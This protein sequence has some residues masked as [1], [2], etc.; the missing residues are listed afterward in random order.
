MEVV[1]AV[2]AW[3]L[4]KFSPQ[5]LLSNLGLLSL[6]TNQTAFYA[7]L[8][9]KLSP[10][11]TILT[12]SEPLFTNATD[13]WR[14]FHSPEIGL[15]VN[16]ASEQ[17]VQEAVRYANKHNMP[18]IARS[19]GHG[20][21][22]ALGAAKN[23]LQIDMRGMNHVIISNDGKTAKIGGG[24]R[25]KEIVQELWDAGKQTVT[26]ICECVGISA[27]I[28]GGG[29]GWL[30]GQYGLATDQVVEARMILS[31]GTAVTVSD[32]SN[33]DLFWAIR[34]A[35]HNFGLVT[36]WKYRIHDI[37]HQNWSYEMFIFTGD[38]LEAIY[39]LTNEMMKSQPPEVIHWA[40]MLKIPEIDPVHPIIFYAIICDGPASKTLEYG[41]PIRDLGPVVNDAG[42]TTMPALA[43]LTYMSLDT[44][45]CAYGFTGL[46]YPIGMNTYNVASVRKVYDEFD[47]MMSS[48]PELSGSF[49]LLEGYS[50]HA[51]KAVPEE[52]TAFAHRSDELL[53]TPYIMY[54]P[55]AKIDPIAKAFGAT[56]RQ[57]LLDGTEDP[58]KLRAYVNY[59]YGD[60]TMQAM[61]GWEEWRLTKLRELKKVWDPESRMRWYNPIV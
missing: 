7:D 25:V 20:A 57:Y 8:T 52:S 34:G 50:T 21:T 59:A 38:K 24:A 46:R 53:L 54:K 1:A 10:D 42:E 14:H 44:A 5:K 49:F 37:K 55:D 31:N 39:E 26:G 4:N 56:M 3:G 47:R 48:T 60:E 51:V 9:A 61:Y 22:E 40:Y 2:A 36:E 41:T 18:F 35:G 15:V 6:V 19:G 17:D 45:G 16:A 43:S 30:Q 28:L 11:A 29:H 33:P 13:R 58:G 23:T 27:T 12:S 32:Y